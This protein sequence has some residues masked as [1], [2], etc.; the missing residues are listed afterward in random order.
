MLVCVAV[1]LGDEGMVPFRK[2]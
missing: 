1:F 2:V